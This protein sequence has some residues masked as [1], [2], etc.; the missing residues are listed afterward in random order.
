MSEAQSWGLSVPK[1]TRI[2]GDTE[3]LKEGIAFASVIYP[4][5]GKV[6]AAA[7]LKGLDALKF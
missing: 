7:A 5:A 1:I 3:K 2:I 4:Q 6:Y